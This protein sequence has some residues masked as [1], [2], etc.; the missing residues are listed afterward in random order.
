MPDA[1]PLQG[2]CEGNAVRAHPAC[3]R[4]LLLPASTGVLDAHRVQGMQCSRRSGV[5]AMLHRDQHSAYATLHLHREP[6]TSCCVDAGRVE[7]CRCSGRVQI[8]CRPGIQEVCG[9]MRRAAN[10]HDAAVFVGFKKRYSDIGEVGFG[11]IEIQHVTLQ[12]TESRINL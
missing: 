3:V 11:V 2:A 8:L 4:R 7:M 6:D 1:L 10:G 9:P 12:R 5:C